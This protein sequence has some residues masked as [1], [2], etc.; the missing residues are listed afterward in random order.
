MEQRQKSSSPSDS[1]KSESASSV[2]ES[3]V[4]VS[5]SDVSAS[6]SPSEVSESPGSEP[7]GCARRL[8]E[9]A[10]RP[11]IV[12]NKSKIPISFHFMVDGSP[13]FI[14]FPDYI[15]RIRGFSLLRKRRD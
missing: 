7:N 11:A 10:D 1:S 4:V 14:N 15:R 3:G 5:A 9:Q 12:M 6:A 2:S 8:E 13:E